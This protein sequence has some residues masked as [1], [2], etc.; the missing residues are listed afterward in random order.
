MR[1]CCRLTGKC[2]RAVNMGSYN[3]LGFAQPTGACADD[4]ERTTRH[5]GVGVCSSRH[6]LGI[7]LLSLLTFTPPGIPFS[8]LLSVS[9][10]H[11]TLPT[12]YSV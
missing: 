5:M 4:A 2:I 9:Y 6:E 7:T 12:I 3:Y 11:L 10:T 1:A 8:Y